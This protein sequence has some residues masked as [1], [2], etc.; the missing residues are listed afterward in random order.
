MSGST[1]V[2][3]IL[4]SKNAITCCLFLISKKLVF[5]PNSWQN[6][7]CF[8]I[9]NLVVFRSTGSFH[10]FVKISK[11]RRIGWIRYGAYFAYC[12]DQPYCHFLLN[13]SLNAAVSYFTVYSRSIRTR[14]LNRFGGWYTL[15]YVVHF[16][17]TT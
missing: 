10:I 2:F 3:L 5:G 15:V 13:S 12:S 8:K 7:H 6:N 17:S 1:S 14:I 11:C 9:L 16:H 4:V